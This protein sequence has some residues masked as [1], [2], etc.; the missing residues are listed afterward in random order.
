MRRGFDCYVGQHPG[1]PDQFFEFDAEIWSVHTSCYEHGYAVFLD[2]RCCQR[3]NQ[4][5]QEE[6]VWHWARDVAYQYAGA[7][8]TSCEL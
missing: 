7:F 2:S 8:F 3:F 6:P 5:A 1:I 4:G